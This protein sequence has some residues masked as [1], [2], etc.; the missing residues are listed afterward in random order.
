MLM[1]TPKIPCVLLAFCLI[2]LLSAPTKLLAEL[3]GFSE[4]PWLGCFSGYEH[5]NF[6]FGVKVDGQCT[7]Y[8]L[9]KNK[10]ERAHNKQF[11]IAAHILHVSGDG[12]AKVLPFKKESGFNTELEAGLDHKEVKFSAETAGD[13][14]AEVTIEYNRDKILLDGRVLDPGKLQGGDIYFEFKVSIPDLYARQLSDLDEREIGKMLRRDKIKFV[15]AEDKKR[16]NLKSYK[17][18]NLA[19]EDM[20]SGGVTEIELRLACLEGMD[21]TFTTDDKR[22]PLQF[23]NASAAKAAPLYKGCVVRWQRLYREQ[24]SEEAGKRISGRNGTSSGKGISPLVIQV[25]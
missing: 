16:V 18:V 2:V 23:E 4:V 22:G 14:R 21:V 24:E 7:L 8:L 3:P 11:N 6:H 1:V 9:Q 5:R 13:A 12:T 15:R 19:D 25:K 10:E 17:D 20:A